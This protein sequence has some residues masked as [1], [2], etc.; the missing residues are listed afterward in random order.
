MEIDPKLTADTAAS[1][2]APIAP[3]L[4]RV[5]WPSLDRRGRRSDVRARAQ[6]ALP[7][8]SSATTVGPLIAHRAF[9]RHAGDARPDGW[10][11]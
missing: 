3:S 1:V 7:V 11:Y 8:N 6:L 10:R 9:D 2:A 4:P 5:D